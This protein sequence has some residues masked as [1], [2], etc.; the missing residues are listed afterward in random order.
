MEGQGI[1]DK[2]LSPASFVE[3]SD[4]ASD[5]DSASLRLHLSHVNGTGKL[6]VKSEPDT[7]LGVNNARLPSNKEGKTTVAWTTTECLLE[8]NFDACI[9][10]YTCQVKGTRSHLHI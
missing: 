3:F 2:I 10:E 7:M 9:I 6:L 1:R 8:R 5:S 4:K